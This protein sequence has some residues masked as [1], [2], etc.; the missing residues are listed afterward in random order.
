[1]Q[2]YIFEAHGKQFAPDGVV[3]PPM[4]AK[5]HNQALDEMTCEVMRQG[6]P[7]VLYLT[8]RQEY[9]ETVPRMI[10]GTWLGKPMARADRYHKSWHNMAGRDG[11]RD[12]WFS[13][14]GHKWHGVN[15]GFGQL[16]R[17]KTVKG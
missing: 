1:M 10:I 2:G 16:L 12:V 7:I 8:E 11:R 13:A 4:D 14:F 5:A 3:N 6:L 15:I 17:C 9:G